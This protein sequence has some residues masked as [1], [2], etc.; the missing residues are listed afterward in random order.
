MIKG[1]LFPFAE[2]TRFTCLQEE[3]LALRVF[4]CLYIDW[5]L[6]HLHHFLWSEHVKIRGDILVQGR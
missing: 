2:Q 5:S 4:G 3:Y 1:C 6:M